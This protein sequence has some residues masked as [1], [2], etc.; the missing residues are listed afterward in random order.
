IA[1]PEL[2][3]WLV[4][5]VGWGGFLDYWPT[6]PALLISRVAPAP[7]GKEVPLTLFLLTSTS[8]VLLLGAAWNLFDFATT[9]HQE[10]FGNP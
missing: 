5:Y 6:L 8:V 4:P 2:R 9:F 1:P 7:A 3:E 10:N